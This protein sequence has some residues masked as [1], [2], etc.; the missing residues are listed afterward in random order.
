MRNI[1]PDNNTRL[2]ILEE[3]VN[4]NFLKPYNNAERKIIFMICLAYFTISI[5]TFIICLYK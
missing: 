1:P 3:R 4:N 2:S 5:F